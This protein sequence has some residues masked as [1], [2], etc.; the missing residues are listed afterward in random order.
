M[1]RRSDRRPPRL[2][3]LRLLHPSLPVTSCLVRWRVVGQGVTASERFSSEADAL[4]RFASITW[5][6]ASYPA[7]F[8][9]LPP[10]RKPETHARLTPTPA[11]RAS[12]ERSQRGPRVRQPALAKAVGAAQ[13]GTARPRLVETHPRCS[14]SSRRF[15]VS[16]GR[17][18]GGRGRWPGRRRRR[19]GSASSRP[20][21]SPRRA[22]RARRG[23]RRSRAR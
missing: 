15:G 20:R 2:L 5:T 1:P 9:S 7:A 17:R 21:S 4:V 19:A 6:A 23:S 13:C 18:G 11:L 12:S 3:R 8:V 22:R 10:S 16:R 14:K